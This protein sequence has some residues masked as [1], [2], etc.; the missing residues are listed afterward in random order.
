MLL[1]TA[2]RTMTALALAGI[3][4]TPLQAQ[5]L[6]VTPPPGTGIEH[7]GVTG[8]WT[9]EVV[10]DGE[11]VSRQEF[12][13]DL[14]GSGQWGLSLLLTGSHSADYWGVLLVPT[15]GVNTVCTGGAAC[16]ILE[17][18]GDLTVT[19]GTEAPFA[20]TL[21]GSLTAEGDGS[22]GSVGT[23]LWMCPTDTQDCSNFANPQITAHNL[24]ANEPVVAGDQINV[25][26]VLTFGTAPAA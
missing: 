26:V 13:N 21:V 18:T 24:P 7:V 25:T 22:I 6:D 8:A 11:V 12:R 1:K 17:S 15:S 23:Q 20:L 3:A 14:I 5:E 2:A 16:A 4:Y 10:R 9:I 19:A